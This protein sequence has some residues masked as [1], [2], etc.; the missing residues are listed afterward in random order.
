MTFVGSC[1]RN[2]FE[3]WLEQCLLPQLQRGNVI[4]IDNAS[5]HHS[6]AID[7][8]VA[9]AGCELWYLPP[10]SPDLNKIE[11]WCE[12][13]AEGSFPPQSFR[14]LY[15]KTGCG[16]GGTNLIAFTTVLMPHLNIVPT[17]LRSAIVDEIQATYRGMMIA[18]APEYWAVFTDFSLE[19]LADTLQSLAAQVRLS[20]F[21][22]QP[23]AP[24]KKKDPPQYDPRHPHV[25]T[26]KLLTQTKKSP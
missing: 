21:L 24:K 3:M 17:C 23:R 7:E 1:N 4:V 20:S 25:S 6:Q 2:L 5:F 18:I 22:K 11:H 19:Q 14:G 8:I 16:I 13:F 26:A 10:Y 15:S 12:T 9:E